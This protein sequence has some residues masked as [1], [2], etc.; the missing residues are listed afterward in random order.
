[1]QGLCVGM[2]RFFLRAQGGG[3]WASSV[4]AQVVVLELFLCGHAR[5]CDVCVD[6]CASAACSPRTALFSRGPA[7]GRRSIDGLS[8][9]VRRFERFAC[10]QMITN[11]AAFAD[12]NWLV[13][14]GMK[15]GAA[16]GTVDGCLPVRVAAGM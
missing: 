15:A 14:M 9:P 16:P 11:R 13:C 8:V 6:W 10:T 4:H 3:G 5:D 2:V 7:R 12:G 1:M